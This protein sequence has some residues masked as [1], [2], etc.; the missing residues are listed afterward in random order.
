MGGV[1]GGLVVLTT[2]F[3]DSDLDDVG[4]P[5]LFAVVVGSLVGL[6]T[7]VPTSAAWMLLVGRTSTTPT[8]ARWVAALA[9]AGIALGIYLALAQSLDWF[10]GGCAVAAGLIAYFA[11]PRVGFGPTAKAR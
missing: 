3:R 5:T 1:L 11:G 9:A 4:V 2:A 6:M 7:A 10:G 8:A